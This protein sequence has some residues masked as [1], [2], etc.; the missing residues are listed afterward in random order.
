MALGIYCP[1]Q[2]V[3]HNFFSKE[4]AS[5]H[6]MAAVTIISD[7]GAQENKVSHCFHCSIQSLSLVQLHGTLWTVAYKGP[8]SQSYDFF[9]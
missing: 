5:F 7:F 1:K 2:Q 3:G 6:F 9:Q 4:Q 8:C